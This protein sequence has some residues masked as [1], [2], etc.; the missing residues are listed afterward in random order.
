MPHKLRANAPAAHM[1]VDKNGI[2][3]S[4]SI[5]PTVIT[6]LPEASSLTGGA[7]LPFSSI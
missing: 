2:N 7:S 3:L 1:L 5:G 4:D 6:I